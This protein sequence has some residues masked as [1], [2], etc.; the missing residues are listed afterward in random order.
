MSNLKLYTKDELTQAD[1]L[2]LN[3]K[4]IQWLL[5]KTPAKYIRK[6]PAKGGGEWS[7]VSGGY[8]KKVLNFMFGFDWDFQVL[9]F[10]MNLD[11]KQAI[12]HGR[13]TVRTNGQAIIKEQFGRAD[14]KFRKNSEQ[15]LDLGN[16]MK[17]AT[18]D[19]LKKC[20]SELG[21]AADVYAPHEFKEID[22]VDNEEEKHLESKFNEVIE[23][24]ES[25]QGED[26]EEIRQECKQA[27]KDGKGVEYFDEI[28]KK[29]KA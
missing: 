21:I 1:N 6:R 26:K 28:L 20:A 16:D 24:L 11:A 2:M 4:Q 12:V 22:V 5:A 19:A 14:I 23:A 25:Y 8:I 9:N 13:L 7:Y 3:T 18:T 17:G 15:P 10:D 27:K 29:L